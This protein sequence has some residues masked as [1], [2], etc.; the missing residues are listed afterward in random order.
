MRNDVRG[1]GATEMLGAASTISRLNS[2]DES[3]R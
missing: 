2:G 1:M 3:S